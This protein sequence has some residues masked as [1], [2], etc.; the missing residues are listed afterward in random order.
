MPSQRPRLVKLGGGKNIRL[1]SRG[2]RLHKTHFSRRTSDL[3]SVSLDEK[4][5]YGMMSAA[6]ASLIFSTLGL[7][8]SP[9]DAMSGVGS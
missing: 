4:I 6:G 1:E 5:R 8:M 9:L 3:R 2:F 7:H